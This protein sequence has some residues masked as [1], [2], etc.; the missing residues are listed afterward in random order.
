[1]TDVEQEQVFDGVTVP[2]DA[3]AGL[4]GTE[5]VGMFLGVSVRRVRKLI[6]TGRLDGEKF[7]GAWLVRSTPEELQ[8]LKEELIVNRERFG[9]GRPDMPRG[10]EFM[11]K[12][13][14]WEKGE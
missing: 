1:M 8:A 7:G 13:W 10:Y 2:P 9:E 4:V 3:T 6:Q 14:K 11:P 5:D 12:D